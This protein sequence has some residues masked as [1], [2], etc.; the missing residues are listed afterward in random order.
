M[1]ILNIH[2]HHAHPGGMEVL[3]AALTKL[4]RERGH[5]VT[6]VSK[7]NAELASLSKKLMAFAGAIHSP[8]V[9]KELAA[10][11]GQTSPKLAHVHNIYPQFSTSALDALHDAGVPVLLHVQDYK[12]TCP[13]A[14]H[15]RQ[16]KL[17]EKCLT[18]SQFNCAIHNCRGS[19]SMSVAYTARNAWARSSG[20]LERAI[21]R[22]L[23]P[24]KFVA[25]L[26][27][28]G[29][30]PADRVRVIPNF[31]D[32]PDVPPRESAGQYIGYIGRIS[33]EKG[34]DVLIEA[35]RKNGISTKIAGNTHLMPQLLDNLP[36]NVEFVGQ[37]DRPGI[38]NFLNGMTALVVPS[39]WYEAFGI[40]CVEALSRG[41]PVIASDIGGLPEV[42]WHNETGL[43]VPPNDPAALAQAMQ[44]LW[45]D[46][47][48]AKQLGHRGYVVARERFTV[49]AFY[50][51]LNSIWSELLET[52]RSAAPLTA[53]NTIR[54]TS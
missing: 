21:S 14:Q 7:Q 33:P 54:A 34:L 4:L 45:D 22:Y 36:G 47:A 9:Y 5:A 2:N 11:I 48:Y 50:K 19:R 38:A 41:I 52:D 6:D 44:Q 16:G 3:Y 13:T 27:I 31:C 28:R 15:L 39:V 12:L 40:V 30:Y 8:S 37:L 23:C 43:L 35:A 42:V 20:R 1:N 32:L 46:P 29:G 10:V 26:T 24:T 51:N 25:D 17:C 18:G 49:E 53:Q